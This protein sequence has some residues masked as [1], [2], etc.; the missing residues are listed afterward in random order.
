MY[1]NNHKNHKLDQLIVE[2]I[3]KKDNNNF[4]QLEIKSTLNYKLI[5]K[6][7]IS[8]DLGNIL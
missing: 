2:N 7:I 1:F 4:Y 8:Y 5:N 6:D 3:S